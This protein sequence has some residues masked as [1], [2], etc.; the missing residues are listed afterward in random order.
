MSTAKKPKAPAKGKA[1]AKK[2]QPAKEKT[3]KEADGN[4]AKLEQML[5]AMGAP[6]LDEGPGMDGEEGVM[7]IDDLAEEFVFEANTDRTL[8]L[9]DL[10]LSEFQKD[11]K[12]GGVPGNKKDETLFL[13]AVN[14]VL[15]F[16]LDS[17]P[18]EM[19]IGFAKSID[20][21]L[22]VALVNK[23]Y[24]VNLMTAFGE[25]FAADNPGLMAKGEGA[26]EEVLGVLEKYQEKWWDKPRDDLKG[27]SANQAM[28]EMA[29][30]YGFL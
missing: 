19:A 7:D 14:S 18:T 8:A 30:K 1:P 21:Y 15:D 5:D 25:D 27:K 17:V 29:E 3:P 28:E 11:I 24:K 23:R 9:K 2:R 12:E 6:K 10:W 4:M 16:V 26:E 20:D 13:M 22:L